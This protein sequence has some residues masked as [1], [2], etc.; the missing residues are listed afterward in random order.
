MN[1]DE[2]KIMTEKESISTD[3]KEY[4]NRYV[5]NRNK[6]IG[7]GLDKTIAS[8]MQEKI[9]NMQGDE[10]ADYLSIV[11]SVIGTADISKIS[12]ENWDEIW[13]AIKEKHNDFALEDSNQYS[14]KFQE[15]VLRDLEESYFS[16][17]NEEDIEKIEY[18]KN[19]VTCMLLEHNKNYPNTNIRIKGRFK[20]DESF[21]DKSLYRASKEEYKRKISDMFAIKI[22]ID[23]SSENFS[24]NSLIFQKREENRKQLLSLVD[25]YNKLQNPDMRSNISKEEYYNNMIKLLGYLQNVVPE[26][27]TDLKQNYK[28]MQNYIKQMKSYLPI[29]KEK[30]MTENEFHLSFMNY[31]K[32]SED[33][34]QSKTDFGYLYD[35]LSAR[36]NDEHNFQL[37]QNQI[38]TLF[39]DSNYGSKELKRFDYKIISSRTKKKS[40]GYVSKFLILDTPAG[41]MEIQLQTANQERDGE[42]GYAAH[43][44]Y[45]NNPVPEI[46]PDVN[47]PE[48]IKHYR[49]VICH[50]T[51][52]YFDAYIDRNQYEP[53]ALFVMKSSY[54]NLK[55]ATQV[56]KGHPLENVLQSYYEEIYKNRK[57]IFKQNSEL[58]DSF[59][60]KD[61]DAYLSSGEVEKL[62]S[63]KKIDS[64]DRDIS[65]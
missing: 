49:S 12:A 42:E 65:D 4:E 28:E 57:K 14:Q 55:T 11:A 52:D 15:H 8:Q 58:Q 18:Y 7:K 48:S 6:I 50:T 56:R 13:H 59:Q 45:K 63:M 46:P 20:S 32:P 3:K 24:P 1:A 47:D 29:T 38:N 5:D 62:K 2:K 34:K 23:D 35:D 54:L 17:H 31:P 39:S 44:D 25:F 60:I 36:I 61:I 21:L 19:F 22:I 40:N 64:D 43:S 51:P 37:L 30:M 9:E 26:E 41:K 16:T 27:A 33:D 10:K 53:A